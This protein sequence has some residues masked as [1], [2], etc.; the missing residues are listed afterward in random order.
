MKRKFMEIYWGKEGQGNVSREKWLLSVPSL[1]RLARRSELA[2]FTGRT[3]RELDYTLVRN[4]VKEFFKAIVTVED[5][6][7]PKPDPEGL[8]KILGDRDPATA[9]YLGDIIDDALS[10]LSAGVAFVGVLSETESQREERAALL[11]NRGA[12]AII[13]NINELESFLRGDVSATV[14]G[15][16]LSY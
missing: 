9:L 4:K 2:I 6:T 12:R 13:S 5:V 1:V 14:P 16:A 3:F 15:N 7:R 10:A 11:M 8:I